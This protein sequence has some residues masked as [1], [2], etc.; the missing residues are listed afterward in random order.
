M[1]YNLPYQ[2]HN[3]DLPHD[4][5][6]FLVYWLI[7]NGLTEI[8]RRNITKI[9]KFHL[10]RKYHWSTIIIYALSFLAFGYVSELFQKMR[11][12]PLEKLCN[13]A[14]M[15]CVKSGIAIF[16]SLEP[17]LMYPVFQKLEDFVTQTKVNQITGLDA[18]HF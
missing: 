12:K 7:G 9:S 15:N 16:C 3:P 4:A 8:F 11:L 18:Y 10:R 1:T 5:Y 17:K 13:R 6:E 2:F 14:M